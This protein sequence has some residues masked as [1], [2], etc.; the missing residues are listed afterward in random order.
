MIYES[1]IIT[2]EIYAQRQRKSHVDEIGRRSTDFAGTRS[3]P[4]SFVSA[5]VIMK[6]S[7][8]RRESLATYYPLIFVF[9]TSETSTEFL[10]SVK[11]AYDHVLRQI[12]RE[13]TIIFRNEEF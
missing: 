1:I 13:A 8:R 7:V 5:T 4:V 2:F 6:M 3:I 12:T 9:E 10:C 11:F